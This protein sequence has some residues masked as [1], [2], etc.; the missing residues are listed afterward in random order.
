[1][2]P[3]SCAFPL[4]AMVTKSIVFTEKK[5]FGLTLAPPPMNIDLLEH[6]TVATR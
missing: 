5:G 3:K 4:V 2:S 1:M 6:P